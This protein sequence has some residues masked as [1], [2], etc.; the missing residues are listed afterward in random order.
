MEFLPL[1]IWATGGF[2]ASMFTKETGDTE[3]DGKSSKAFAQIWLLGCAI[4]FALGT[5][6][7]MSQS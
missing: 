1:A 7:S 5:F 6:S 2:C 3:K 4:F